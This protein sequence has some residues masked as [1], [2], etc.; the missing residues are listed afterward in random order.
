MKKTLRIN[1]SLS[2]LGSIR[3]MAKMHKKTSD[4]RAIINF[5]RHPTSKI[6]VFFLSSDQ[7][8]NN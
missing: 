4:W 7:T 2:K 6:S 5:K 8:N 1:E 3:L